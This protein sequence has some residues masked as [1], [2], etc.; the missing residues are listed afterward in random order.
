AASAS[1][2][3][4]SAGSEGTDA[5]LSGSGFA[6]ARRRRPRLSRALR[7]VLGAFGAAQFALGILQAAGSAAQHDHGSDSPLGVNPG[8]LWHESAAWNV[9]IGAGFAWIALRRGRPNGAL[10][11]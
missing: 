11:M 5:G 9:A 2:A 3:A 8:H 10:P 4:G 6:G 1:I 7:V